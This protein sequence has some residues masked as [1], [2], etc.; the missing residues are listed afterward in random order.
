MGI[1]KHFPIIEMMKAMTRRNNKTCKEEILYDIKK[2][3]IKRI[4]K[5]YE[6][7]ISKTYIPIKYG[8]EYQGRDKEQE[9][10]GDSGYA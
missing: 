9:K 1:E 3:K 10:F 8:E 2:S 5:E 4:I 7:N 6:K